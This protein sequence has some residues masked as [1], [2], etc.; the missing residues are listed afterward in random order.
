M[1]NEIRIDFKFSQIEYDSLN[2]N[3]YSMT[4]CGIWRVEYIKTACTNAR[5]HT[6]RPY[7]TWAKDGLY[8]VRITL[9]FHL[10]FWI[11]HFALSLLIKKPFHLAH[12]HIHTRTCTITVHIAMCH[13]LSVLFARQ[14]FRVL[15]NKNWKHVRENCTHVAQDGNY[16]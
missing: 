2:D 13:C 8:C 14:C 12:T 4:V 16:E 3:D 9:F 6:P 7:Y 5:A 11:T 10:A 15:A 1:R